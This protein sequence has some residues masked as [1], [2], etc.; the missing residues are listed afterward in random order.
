MSLIRWLSLWGP[1]LYSNALSIPPMLAT[2]AF[3]GELQ[4]VHAGAA[5]REGSSW[6]AALVPL[7][8]SCLAAVG[9]SFFGW[10]CRD[11]CSATGF[12]LLGVANKLL[13][14]LASALLTGQPLSHAGGM[15]LVG[16]LFFAAQYR[17][18]PP[19]AAV[20]E[21]DRKTKQG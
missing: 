4:Q 13:S 10:R 6:R 5:L 11:I 2:A 18:A 17:P 7:S 14:T 21:R 9:I 12:T 16:C 19:V 3:G 8:L 1:V 20:E 15:C